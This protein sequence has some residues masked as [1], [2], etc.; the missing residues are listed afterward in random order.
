MPPKWCTQLQRN[1]SVFLPAFNLPLSS[2]SHWK[3]PSFVQIQCIPLTIDGARWPTSDQFS[4]QVVARDTHRKENLQVAQRPGQ[5]HWPW[6]GLGWW[7]AARINQASSRL[8]R[9][10]AKQTP[11]RPVVLHR[12]MQIQR[13]DPDMAMPGCVADLGQRTPTS[14]GMADKGMTPVMNGHLSSPLGAQGPTG[15]LEA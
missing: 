6:R 9:H 13:G 12:D 11:H 14:Q 4:Q 10:K 1:A 5:L 8:A 15:S 7:P 2:T 3:R